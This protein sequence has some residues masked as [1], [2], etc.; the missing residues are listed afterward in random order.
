[1]SFQIHINDT[2]P[3]EFTEW[4][5]EQNDSTLAS[6]LYIGY[7]ALQN[8]ESLDKG[9]SVTEKI[10]DIVSHYL[11]QLDKTCFSAIETIKSDHHQ[12]IEKIKQDH[13]TSLHHL[14]NESDK[15][16]S[17][18]NLIHSKI[19]HV[20]QIFSGVTD[21]ITQF[22]SLIHTQL[23]PL[24]KQISFLSE[25]VNTM[26]KNTNNSSL[27]GAMGENLVIDAL[28]NAFPHIEIRDTS[29]IPHQGD[30]HFMSKIPILIEVKTYKTSVTKKPID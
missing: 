20:D 5:S 28:H 13:T 14:Q 10:K 8:K 29:H 3:S 22:S 6:A 16:E 11:G 24:Q 18:L 2:Y 9:K 1:M 7:L 23:Q 25:S 4:A 15:K 12:T 21:Q 26:T 27:K 19:N 17:T 30:F